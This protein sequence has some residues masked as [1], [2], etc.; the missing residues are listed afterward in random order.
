M[1]VTMADV[2]R[3]AMAMFGGPYLR[4]MAAPRWRCPAGRICDAWL[5]RDGDVR[6]AAMAMFGWMR[7]RCPVGR[8]NK[9]KIFRNFEQE[10]EIGGNK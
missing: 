6:R 4:C 5:R 9:G 1:T 8:A 7:L 3:G 10:S 2:R